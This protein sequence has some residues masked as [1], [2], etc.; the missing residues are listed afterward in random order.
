VSLTTL[1]RPLV[2][3]AVGVAAVSGGHDTASPPAT[4]DFVVVSGR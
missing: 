3:V 2:P 1:S 4:S